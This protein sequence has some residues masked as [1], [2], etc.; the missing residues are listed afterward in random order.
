MSD[1][2]YNVILA[3]PPWNYVNQG[4]RAATSNHYDQMSLVKIKELP[5]GEISS[6]PSALFLWATWPNLLAALEVIEA[7]GFEYKTIAWV[8]LKLDKAGTKPIMGLGNYTRSNTEP[9]LLAFKRIKTRG[10]SMPVEDHAVPAWIMSPRRKHS[11]KPDE[12]YEYIDRLYPGASRLELFA[13]K[14]HP[15]W[16]VWGHEVANTVEL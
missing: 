7:W 9:C 8:W 1:Q 10:M 11:Q 15:G 5:I 13:R 14:A 6:L 2:L 12:Q 4:T 3:D 16:D